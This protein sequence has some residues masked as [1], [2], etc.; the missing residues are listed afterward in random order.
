MTSLIPNLLFLFTLGSENSGRKDSEKELLS[1]LKKLEL[2]SK[3]ID[4][5]KIK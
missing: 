1:T 2:E 5:G 3:S 4:K